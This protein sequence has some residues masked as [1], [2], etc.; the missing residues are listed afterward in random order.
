MPN[1][2]LM[3]AF[4]AA[5]FVFAV[6]PGPA[7]L[8]TAAQTL[9]RGTRAG[10]VAGLGLHLGGWA[11]V[12]AAALGLALVFVAVPWAYTGFKIAGA[13]YL[14]YL[15]LRLVFAPS[16]M[17]DVEPDQTFQNERNALWQSMTVEILNPKT[18]LFFLAFLPQFTDPAASFPIWLQL[19]I[20]GAIVNAMFS[21]VDIA[22]V[23]VARQ[24]RSKLQQNAT[25][26][27]WAQRIGGTI[28]MGLA[29]RL[30]FDR[31]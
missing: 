11:H 19:L 17:A 26:A 8:Y 22:T 12:F 28:L 15:G 13:L 2:D 21:C 4:F 9:A 16:K 7:I 5:A 20:L 1:F 31:G 14:T 10:W 23:N 27:L 3:A 6:M 30:A 25:G 29:A 24:V 18:A